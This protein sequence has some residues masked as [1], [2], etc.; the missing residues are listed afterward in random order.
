ML[1]AGIKYTV[2]VFYCIFVIHP[3]IHGWTGGLPAD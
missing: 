2:A 3:V 1:H